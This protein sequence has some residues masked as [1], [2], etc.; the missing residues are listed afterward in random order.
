MSKRVQDYLFQSMPFRKVTVSCF[1]VVED[2]VVAVK[3]TEPTCLRR[4]IPP[5]AAVVV[6]D[7]SLNNPLSLVLPSGTVAVMTAVSFPIVADFALV[8]NLSNAILSPCSDAV[9]YLDQFEDVLLEESVMS[10]VC[11]DSLCVKWQ[12][13]TYIF[14]I[15]HDVKELLGFLVIIAELV[16]SFSDNEILGDLGPHFSALRHWCRR[17]WSRSQADT[18]ISDL[19]DLDVSFALAFLVINLDAQSITLPAGRSICF[20]VRDDRRG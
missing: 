9:R 3:R 15:L 19:L 7:L 8:L 1:Q 6:Y 18:P 17:R 2:H 14:Q 16:D 10:A 12:G 20:T 13:L 5:W 4:L 11:P